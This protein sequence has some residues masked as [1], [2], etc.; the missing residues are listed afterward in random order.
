[1]ILFISLLFTP[2]LTSQSCWSSVVNIHIQMDGKRFSFLQIEEIHKIQR[3]IFWS[4]TK[5][6]ASNNKAQHAE[7]KE[8]KNITPLD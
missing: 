8:D 7:K 6:L 2:S 1:M 4:I 5:Y 3:D